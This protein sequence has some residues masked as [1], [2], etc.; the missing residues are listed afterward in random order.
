MSEPA[1]KA[2]GS[3]RFVFFKDNQQNYYYSTD[4]AGVYGGNRIPS[5]DS[6]ASLPTISSIAIP[7]L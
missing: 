4:V 3:L 7:Q 2:Y 1:L 6:S 5:G